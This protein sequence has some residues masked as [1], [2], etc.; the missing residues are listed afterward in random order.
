MQGMKLPVYA[1]D[2]SL[3]ATQFTNNA[4]WVLM[5]VLRRS[6]WTSAEL[7]IS[8]FASAAA[9]CD[10]QI[11]SQ[12]L[13]GNATTVSRFQCNLILKTRRTAA[14]AIRGIRNGSRL[15]LTYGAGGLLQLRV[16]NTLALQQPAQVASSNS[17][18]LLNGG[19]PAYEFGDGSSGTTGLLRKASGEPNLRLYS[20]SITDTPNSFSVEFQDSFNEY[21]QDSLSLT[22]VADVAQIGQEIRGPFSVLG[23]P[24][25]D[26]AARVLKFNLDRS[27]QGNTYVQ[28]ETSVR[29]IGIQ[30]GDIVSLTYLKEGFIRQPFRVIGIAPGTNYRT[31]AITA[32]IHNDAWYSDTNGQG[33]ANGRRQPGS[34]GLPRPLTGTIVDANGEVQ[35]GI[36][37]TSSGNTDGG[38]TVQANV[39]FFSPPA[40]AV[41]QIGIPLLNFAP[42]FGAG[43]TLAANQTLYYVFSAVDAAGDE[44][45]L[46]FVVP[47]SIPPGPN[48][49]SVTISGLSFSSVTT[50]FNVYR[51]PNPSELF[52]IASNHSVS[53][54]FT[55]TGFPE[56]LASPPDANFD[57]A[58]FYWRLELQPEYSAT[59]HSQTT[60]GNSTLVMVVNANRGA[61]ARI[62]RGRGVGQ[63]RAVQSNTATTLT[64]TSPWD[65][66]PDATSFFTIAESGWHFG[67]TGST[68]P[69][70]FEIPN[71]ALAIV[72]ITG[73]AANA[74]DQ[75]SP[76]ELATATR[77]LIGGSGIG[78]PDG[79]VP[80]LP[81]FGIGL[82]PNRGGYLEIGGIG[83]LH[84][85]N[86]ETIDAATFTIHY[87]D[88]IQG[89]PLTLLSAAILASD[90]SIS[91]TVAGTS[92]AGSFIQIETEV[93][94]IIGVLNNG[95]QYLVTRAMHGT[96]AAAHASQTVVY[97]L[98]NSV[99]IASFTRNFFGSPSGDGWV[100]PVLL[101]DARVAS[102]ELVLTNSR[103]D[104]PTA[105]ISVTQTVDSGLR[106]L[107]G[108][109]YS[110]DVEG[111]LAIENGAAPDL[112][113]EAT[114]SVR[115]IYAVVRQAPTDS[116]IQ[117][118]LNQALPGQNPV[119][120][121][122][123]T[124]LAGAVI[125][126]FRN[127]FLLPPLTSGA[128]VSL[129][130]TAVGG[131]N[132]GSDLTVIIRL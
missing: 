66:Q 70:Q 26:Q 33:P 13:Y 40:P 20:R 99:S 16:E 15:Y 93:M 82:I 5:D 116:P 91:L 8:S 42:T 21:Q 111:F 124:I 7:D 96:T 100:L 64:L 109:Q 88:E 84:P 85:T 76:A 107:S 25:Y 67:A 118:R 3:T 62:T 117:I 22:N 119:A 9:Y 44:S 55:D 72:Q 46:S 71:R 79:D 130:I 1:P 98:N 49:N 6:G 31:A 127:G 30:P 17:T 89:Q 57:H 120:Y 129:D 121:C 68:S 92:P 48:T 47:A 10:A 94:Q 126:S 73:R 101:P 102:A 95:T 28:F 60:I 54:Q 45:G 125:S 69:L 34:G 19:W 12:D 65:M 59:L 2:G 18:V 108:G 106:T 37:E 75:E 103:G 123:L 97:A 39:S 27:I 43:G 128:R 113:M 24:N 132:P 112:V 122:T 56:Q 110:I 50:G 29:A 38:S 4:A 53:A 41:N 105:V 58:N 23:I 61:V 81:S 51:G 14:D 78:S 77:W 83:F 86:I 35:F 11:P 32:Q 104:S 131:T 115:D 52:R 87:F 36:V 114:H 63:E 74:D 90:Q 80:P